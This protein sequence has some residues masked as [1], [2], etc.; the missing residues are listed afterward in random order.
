MIH[1]QRPEWPELR[2]D[3]ETN[4]HQ[5]LIDEYVRQ[6]KS[7]DINYRFESPYIHF[8]KGSFISAM[9]KKLGDK[10][11]YCEKS[12]TGI[13]NSEWMLNWFR[14]FNNALQRDEKPHPGQP[15][16]HYFWLQWTW[17]NM[18]LA[19]ERC[20]ANKNDRFPVG[21][22][23]AD[24]GVSS[25]ELRN[26]NP[27]LL[28]PCDPMINPLCSLEFTNDGRVIPRDEYGETTIYILKLNDIV[29]LIP[30]RSE[31]CTKIDDIFDQCRETAKSYRKRKEAL[32]ITQGFFAPLL[33]ECAKDS[34][35]AGAKRW[36]VRNLLEQNKQL[37]SVHWR[38]LRIV[39]KAWFEPPYKPSPSV[40]DSTT[41]EWSRSGSAR[42]ID[43]IS[44][45]RGERNEYPV[46]DREEDNA[47]L[48]PGQPNIEP[49][50][51]IL[52]LLHPAE[53]F[54]HTRFRQ[55]HEALLSAFPT[56]ASLEQMVFLQMGER[57]QVIVGYSGTLSK[58]VLDLILWADSSGRLDELI[59]GAKAENPR[60]PY[61]KSL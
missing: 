44:V 9:R 33:K 6:C 38:G 4:K 48:S 37:K 54:T 19:C 57:L 41:Q 34:E 49:P 61:L 39:V 1:F 8:K 35:F 16:P 36:R 40:D 20:A 5:E 18:Y 23:R 17:E 46:L 45:D 13:P 24:I 58:I 53:K 60:N 52:P 47:R 31:A 15:I 3:P 55:F 50:P 10:C 26:E 7:G 51:L 42:N 43:N 28:D 11:L 29:G 30:A 2:N 22:K 32:E 27:L 56:Y 21:N 25:D 12:L 14:P 59:E